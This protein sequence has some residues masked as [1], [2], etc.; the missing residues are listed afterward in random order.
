MEEIIV[1]G[2]CN[3]REYEIQKDKKRW[4]TSLEQVFLM[5]DT[6]YFFPHQIPE[7]RLYEELNI[8][9][10]IYSE[11]EDRGETSPTDS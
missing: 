9:S 4:Y 8:Y 10:P 11:L 6:E 1:M 3:G 7:D 2:E 5:I